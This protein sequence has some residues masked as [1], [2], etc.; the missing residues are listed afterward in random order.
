MNTTPTYN[1]TGNYVTI[2]GVVVILLS[3]LGIN[4][5]LATIVTIIGAGVSV[6]GIIKQFIAHKA[7]AKA[8]NT[9]TV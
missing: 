4:T 3:K 5:D 1:Q 7:L 6:Y 9:P 2:A 8:T